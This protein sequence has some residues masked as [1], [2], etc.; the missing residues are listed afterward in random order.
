MVE[1][2]FTCFKLTNLSIFLNPVLFLHSSPFAFF[3]PIYFS[4][5]TSFILISPPLVNQAWA[6]YT[7]YM[8]YILIMMC[9]HMGV[10][11][12]F[13]II[14]SILLSEGRR[15]DSP[16]M[17]VE[18]SLG[19]MLNSKLFL[20]CWLAPCMEATAISVWITVSHF[21]QKRLLNALK[22]KWTYT[23]SGLC[24]PGFK[25]CISIS[26]SIKC[27]ELTDILLLIIWFK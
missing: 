9:D 22:C 7:T 24:F 16:G 26:I 10:R 27:S 17:H 25:A 13:R 18:V 20:L 5:Q 14:A 1:W 3:F 15:F 11:L 2:L 8:I 6:I 4:L 23:F 12:W 19:K 21:G